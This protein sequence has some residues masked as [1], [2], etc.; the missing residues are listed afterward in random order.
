MAKNRKKATEVIV[1]LISELYPGTENGGLMRRFLEKMNDQ[2]FAQYMEDLRSGKEIVT[3]TIPNFS[4]TKFDEEHFLKFGKK[5]KIEFFHHLKVTD[6]DTGRVF[7]TP[8]RYL[9]IRDR[10]NRLQQM[11]E[12][13]T[14]FPLDNNHVDELSGQV[15]N[16]SKGARLSFP[17]TNNL[18]AKGFRAFIAEAI[19][20]RGGNAKALRIFEDQLRSTGVGS[21]TTALDQ[22]DGSKANHTLAAYLRAMTFSTTLDRSLR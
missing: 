9:V 4:K 12:D 13:K 22:S 5:Y 19:G 10:V 3:V 18:N 1:S 7:T 14:S 2:E 20:V 17:E 15:T 6:P 11:L 21:I 16:E 8:L